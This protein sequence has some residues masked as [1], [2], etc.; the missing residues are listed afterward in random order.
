MIEAA[1]GRAV[2]IAL[3][4]IV[5]DAGATHVRGRGVGEPGHQVADRAAA[6]PAPGPPRGKGWS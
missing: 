2:V 5:L 3:G 1:G 6:T 4:I